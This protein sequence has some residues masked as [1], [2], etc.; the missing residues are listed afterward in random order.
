MSARTSS[1]LVHG[2]HATASVTLSLQVIKSYSILLA[3]LP[4]H[5]TAILPPQLWSNLYDS[6]DFTGSAEV[7]DTWQGAVALGDWG[8]DLAPADC[9]GAFTVGGGAEEAVFFL[10]ASKLARRLSS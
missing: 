1:K 6:D 9:G 8:G 7:G 2:G 5:M 4:A 10:D 3:F